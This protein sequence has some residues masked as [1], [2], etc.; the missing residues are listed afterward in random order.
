[1]EEE[2][3]LSEGDGS[4]ELSE[5]A[6][7]G[8]GDAVEEDGEGGVEEEGEGDGGVFEVVEVVGGDGSIRVEGLVAVGAYEEFHGDG[9]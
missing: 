6:F 1:M 7:G 4:E 9:G 3:L 5:G 2:K 8:G